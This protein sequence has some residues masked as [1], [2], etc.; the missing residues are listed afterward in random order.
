MRCGRVCTCTGEELSEEKTSN[1]MV[2]GNIVCWKKI[3]QAASLAK[4]S[5]AG[6]AETGRRRGAQLLRVLATAL[7]EAVL[8][9]ADGVDGADD[10]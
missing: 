2:H 1:R 3:L 4:G 7:D 5:A 10:A 8:L 6:A 9:E